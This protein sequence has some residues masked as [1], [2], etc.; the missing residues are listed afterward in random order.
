[1]AEE[2]PI[3]QLQHLLED[4][5]H[6]L[7]R[8][9]RIRSAIGSSRPAETSAIGLTAH[10]VS[11]YDG[12]LRMLQDMQSQIDGQVRPLALRAMQAE[13]DRL[14][15]LAGRELVAQEECLA[16]LD[17]ALSACVDRIRESRKVGEGLASLNRRLSDLGA[18]T[19]E[20]TPHFDLTAG[21]LEILQYRIEALRRYGRL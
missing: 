6:L 2:D 21:P 15:A 3:R 12:L 5:D 1:M 14:R 13:A 17:R 11:P 18:P 20:W 8:I 9:S 7:E 19:E 10:D 16:N 4:P